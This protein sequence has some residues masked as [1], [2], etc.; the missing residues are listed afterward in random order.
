MAKY[1]FNV[2]IGADTRP[3]A[4]ALR[5]L[6]K[7]INDA[8]KTLSR[9]NEGLKLN[10][11]NAN[12]I[13]SKFKTLDFQME[14]TQDKLRGLKEARDNLIKSANGKYTEEQY[15]TLQKLNAEIE[16][17]EEELKA[18]QKQY[19]NLGSVGLQQTIALGEKMKDL[20][21]KIEQAGQK[22][23]I[24]SGLAAGALGGIIKTSVDFEDA[25]VGVTK[26]VN[27][28][29]E[30]LAQV[31][32]EI[33]N[34]SKVT[35][36]SKNEIAGVAQAAGQLGIAT[37]DLSEFTKVMIDLG[38]STNLSSE[39]AAISL[40]RLANITQM[41]SK[42]YGRL[43]ATITDLGNNFAITESE[44]VEMGTRLAS[45]GDLVGLNQ[46]QIMALA[47]AM[48]SLG[49]ESEAGGTAMS[50]MF[51]KMQLAVA[52]NNK[53]LKQFA[54]VSGMSVKEFKAAFEKDALGTLNSFVKGLAKIE[55]GG[56]SA[57]AKLDEMK[58]SEV[59]LSD[60]TLRLVGSGE[61]LDRA[62]ET[63]NT[64][65]EENT[66]L[67]K[68]AEKRQNETLYTWKQVIETLGELAV[69]IGDVLLPVIKQILDRLQVWIDRFTNLDDGTK[70]VI[71]AI[72]LIVAA[73]APFLIILGKLLSVIGT[74]I[75]TFALLGIAISAISAPVLAIIAVIGVLIGIIIKLWNTNEDFRNN[76]MNIW[77]GLV[78]FF[79][80]VILPPIVGFL[81]ILKGVFGAV[82]EAISGTIKT[83]LHYVMT[84]VSTVIAE[85]SGLITF[86]QGVFT[87]NWRQAWE[88]IK[89]IFMAVIEGIKQV[90]SGFINDIT[91]MINGITSKLNSISVG[92]HSLNIP[93]IPALA[94]GGIVNRP[95]LAMVGEGGSSEAVVPLDRL[96]SIMAQAMKI[97]GGYNI[98]IYTQELD[99]NKLEQIVEYVDKRFGASY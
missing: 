9:I 10:P 80:N 26:T 51:R 27:G 52:T 76:V 75:I 5:E 92:G 37:S 96:P 67:T 46:A 20:G 21:G 93:Q 28:T 4:T 40:A 45:T 23:K 74:L 14:Q 24:I 19:K 57:I 64:A 17:T 95:T 15:Q 53:Q 63:A 32:Q 85:F 94:S 36:V 29:E 99:S 61:L 89:Q 79:Q 41:S 11:F 3:F 55:D 81:N 6:N 98:T 44:I 2:T 65:W 68:E 70:K 60:A 35:G 69:K 43:G 62:I 77:N 91:N 86:L 18:L 97:G 33:L 13:T 59:R 58:L 54:E 8:Q 12:L 88:G 38:M 87:L 31:R 50:K 25:W 30:E 82:F 78:S 34:M 1:G 72:L 73:I 71:I 56:G 39:E 83:F 7:P 22:F 42:D 90:F 49:S 47:T 84:V 66:A 16:V 48:G